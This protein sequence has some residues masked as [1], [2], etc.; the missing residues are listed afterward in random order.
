MIETSRLTMRPF[1]EADVQAAFRW[2]G[3]S[4]VMRF[5]PG[6]PNRSIAQTR[7]RIARYLSHQTTH[8]FSKWIIEERM[9]SLPV[10]DAGLLVLDEYG[11]I[12]LGFRLAP[13][14]WGQ[15]YA[16]EAA[17]AWV[18]AAFDEFLLAR[19]GAFTHPENL[20]SIRVLEK[21]GFR[22][23]RRDTVMGMESILFSLE[24]A[25]FPTSTGPGQ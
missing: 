23:V 14:H 16:T 12:D 3:D 2:F 7:A 17:S 9:S 5:T 13:S 24:K 1:A 6:G 21:L 15:G 10:G 18:R 20:A 4:A 8:G 25:D 22:R 19:L 11:W